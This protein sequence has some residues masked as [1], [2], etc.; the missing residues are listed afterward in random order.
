[1][2]LVEVRLLDGPNVYRLEPAVKVEVAIGRRRTWF[3]ERQPGRHAIV[4][5]G[6]PVRGAE[7]PAAVVALAGWVRRLHTL[8]GAARWLAQEP[9]PDGRPRRVLPVTV[10]LTSDPGHWVVAF[11]WRERDR[12]RRIAEG[13]WRLAERGLD[14]GTTRIRPRGSTGGAQRPSRLL[15]RV[16]E[17]VRAAA[18]GAPAWIRDRDRRVPIVSITGTNGK[19]TTTRMV[20]HILRLAGRRVGTTTSDGVLFDERMVEPGDYTGPAG[21]KR[22]LDEAEVD[23]AVLETARGGIVLR[24]VGYESNDAAVLTNVSADHLD[25]HGLHTLPE[26]AEVKS[27]IARITRPSGLVVLNGDDRLVAGAARWVRAP[28]CFFSLRPGSRRI[29][30]HLAAGGRAMILEEGW[31][32]EA[33]GGE[34]SRILPVAEAPATLFGL[35]RHNIANALAAAGATRALG[36]SLEEVGAGLRDYRPSAELAPGRLNLYRLD[37][38]VVIVD[39]AH[40]EAGLSVVLDVAEGIARGEPGAARPITVI[41]GTAGD[42]PDDALRGIGLIA[43]RRGDRVAIKETKKYLRGRSRRAVVGEILAGMVQGGARRS[44]VPIFEDEKEALRAILDGGRSDGDRGVYVLMC[45]EDREGVAVVL[46]GMGARPID[47]VTG[48][49]ELVPSLRPSGS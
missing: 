41:A 22:V 29:R 24:G 47:A 33:R 42:R 45:Q 23:V 4:R 13:A 6:A 21:A 34:R 15:A 37:D 49:A 3:G 20:T 38:R 39:F 17:D 30:R 9:G 5:L 16:V 25:L 19:S 43:A 48:L 14:P 18:D 11:P 2:R 1:M 46:E 31:L 28:V 44:Q 36:L 27:V 32:V 10:H 26:L 8:T 35:A 12:A 7:V 40:N